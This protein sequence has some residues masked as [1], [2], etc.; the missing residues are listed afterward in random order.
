MLSNK[1][2]VA[3]FDFGSKN[4]KLIIGS[5]REGRI[6][7]YDYDIIQTPN[8]AISDGK[9]IDKQNIINSLSKYMKKI[10]KINEKR[11]VISSSEVILRTFDLPKMENKEL[12]EAIVYEMGV[13]LPESVDSY[14]LDCSVMLEYEKNGEDGKNVDMLKVQGIAIRKEIIYDYLYCF[15]KLGI[16]IDVIDVQSNSAIKLFYNKKSFNKSK[17]EKNVA[18]IDFGHQKTSITI[19]EG[20]NIFLHR[21]INKGGLD[22][23]KFIAEIMNTNFENAEKWKHK[24][25]FKFIHK[26]N[27]NHIEKLL[28]DR[29]SIIFNDISSELY[30]IIEFFV[31][32]SRQR[33]L[34]KIYLVGG[35]AFIPHICEYIA[36]HV[37]TPTELGNLYGGLE[38]KKIDGRIV[39]DDL[40]Y[41]YNCMGIL[42]RRG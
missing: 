23:T 6:T 9:I 29:I 42:I 20:Y 37:D 28:Y 33:K 2:L 15:D 41:L 36:E 27:K 16:K 35:G 18:I 4:I 17:K 21:V 38:V 34:D 8:G 14:V 32:S 19:V 5:V 22:I 26:P 39:N 3:A 40:L 1:N 10:K 11:L 12:N 30:K 24:N 13:L 7:I 31:S 25:S